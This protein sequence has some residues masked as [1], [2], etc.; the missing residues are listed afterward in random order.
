MRNC[1]RADAAAQA[2]SNFATCLGTSAWASSS[3]ALN[4]KKASGFGY[5]RKR[6]PRSERGIGR[7]SQERGFVYELRRR[8]V[9]R[10]AIAY[11]VVAWVVLQLA[12]IVFPA[13]GAPDWVLKVVIAVL[14]LGFPI[15]LVLAW[16]YELTPDGIRRTEPATSP[17]ARAPEDQQRVGRQLNRVIIGVMGLVI[18]VLLA[19]RFVPHKVGG[20]ADAT[21]SD[22]SIAVLP[23]VNTSGDE[24]NE[25]FSDG[26]S[27]E[28]IS[29]LGKLNDLTVIGRNSSFQ[30]KGKG[31]DSKAIAAK[32][33]VAY[34]LEGS[35]RKASD[36][37]RIVVELVRA[38]NGANVWSETYERD[39]RD[40]FAVQTEIATAVANQLQSRLLGGV[41][42]QLQSDAPPNGNLDAHNAYLLGKFHYERRNEAEYRKSIE[43]FALATRL[44]PKY[45]LAWA[46]R[47]RV[48]SALATQHLEGDEQRK[49]FDEARAASDTSLALAPDLAFAHIWR[50]YLLLNADLDLHGAEAELR[51]ALQLAPDNADANF[52][53]GV[54]MAVT[55]RIGRAVELAQRALV[56]DPLNGRWYA[57][58]G[59]YLL[60][61]GRLDDAEVATR[62]AIELQPDAVANY[63]QIAM[64]DVLR[65]DAVGALAAARE[66]H[67]GAWRDY[68]LALALQIGSDRAAADAALQNV[69]EKE[70]GSGP[71]QIAQAYAARG[72][73]DKVFEWLDRAYA[74]HDPGVET[75]HF[76]P[77]ILRFK[78]D[79]RFAAYCRRLGL[80]TPDEVAAQTAAATRA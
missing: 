4:D 70:S 36:R 22:K 7:M 2:P 6:L 34:L 37:V 32:L 64:I 17:E 53:F 33:G 73:A 35:V 40:I 66:E 5:H 62:R 41:K 79:P 14:A 11:A 68:A 23:L 18:L 16:A 28:L 59:N 21:V 26:I 80:P 3:R 77:L 55:G 1:N 46:W 48:L 65:G 71:Y 25:Y 13:F 30:F 43:Q 51:R 76:D 42:A 69:I 56:T 24:A 57:W 54:M 72:D 74:V 52:Q 27:E 78:S 47:A 45:A 61:L 20:G 10:A 49:T 8:H 38:A 29:T 31:E 44:D 39:L 60:A 63:A 19:E 12:S 67:A 9:V 75:V 15:A 58:L 50:G